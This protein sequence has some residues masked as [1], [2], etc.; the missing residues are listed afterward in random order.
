MMMGQPLQ[1]ANC[2]PGFDTAVNGESPEPACKQ[3]EGSRMTQQLGRA[4]CRC[5]HQNQQHP[6]QQ[7]LDF[8]LEPLHCLLLL[9]V[10]PLDA[11]YCVAVI[12]HVMPI[13]K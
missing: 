4:S 8:E 10:M 7:R 6:P 5:T 9:A 1:A 12:L 13:N 3:S 11:E 2:L